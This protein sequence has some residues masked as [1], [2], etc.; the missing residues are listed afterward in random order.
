M[1]ISSVD[2]CSEHS[3]CTNTN[4]IKDLIKV[5]L[6]QLWDLW[7]ARFG[8]WLHTNSHSV[9]WVR[10]P[11]NGPFPPQTRAKHTPEVGGQSQSLVSQHNR[12][13]CHQAARC[14]LWHSDGRNWSYL[15]RSCWGWPGQLLGTPPSHWSQHE[16]S[17][18]RTSP[19]HWGSSNTTWWFIFSISKWCFCACTPVYTYAHNPRVLKNP[20]TVHAKKLQARSSLGSG[21]TEKAVGIVKHIKRK[22]ILTVFNFSEHKLFYATAAKI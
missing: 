2:K 15:Q 20:S 13:G 16:L 10:F 9:T 22:F 12:T 19:K 11:Q 4:N 6:K 7:Y 8:L 1:Q 5:A 21:S 18:L 14:H 3:S 17:L